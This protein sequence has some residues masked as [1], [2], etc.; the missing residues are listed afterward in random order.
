MWALVFFFFVDF[1]LALR[2][3]DWGFGFRDPSRGYR[4]I[5]AVGLIRFGV[6][7]S[8]LHGDAIVTNME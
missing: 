4:F 2:V 1:G 7:S 6:L 8:V 5:W 3:K